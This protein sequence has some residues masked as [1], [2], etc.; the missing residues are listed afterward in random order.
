MSL[1]Y[2][3]ST[4]EARTLCTNENLNLKTYF[5]VTRKIQFLDK[6]ND[7]GSESN[8]D[9]A[10]MEVPFSSCLNT[11]SCD[12]S[13]SDDGK[14]SFN[15]LQLIVWLLSVSARKISA[16]A[17]LPLPLH[18]KNLYQLE[19]RDEPASRKS[20]YPSPLTDFRKKFRLLIFNFI[21]Y[22]LL[23]PQSNFDAVAGE[24]IVF[25]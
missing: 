14:M 20:F 13:S 2:C 15:L 25:L 1:C 11:S 21:F 7:S 10:I 6:V 12:S 22:A 18:Q 9:S 16:L 17:T 19:R 8:T 4:E 5:K 23:S 24:G 3:D